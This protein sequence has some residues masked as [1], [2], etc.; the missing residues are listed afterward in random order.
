MGCRVG[1]GR[2]E[3]ATEPPGT[4]P[5]D[6]GMV[7]RR[8]RD[9]LHEARRANA[10]ALCHGPDALSEEDAAAE[11]QRRHLAAVLQA[12]RPRRFSLG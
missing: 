12:E 6:E 5:G 11:A 4:H 7:L 10:R 9:R 1:G 3:T 2:V 8:E